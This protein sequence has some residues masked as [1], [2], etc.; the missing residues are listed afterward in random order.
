MHELGLREAARL[1]ARAREAV[2]RHKAVAADVE[3]LARRLGVAEAGDKGVGEVGD[4]A[5]L[6]D[7]VWF[8]LVVGSFFVVGG[9]KGAGW[10][11]CS[12]HAHRK[13]HSSDTHRR[14]KTK[15][16]STTNL[17]AAAGHDDGAAGGEAVEEVLLDGVVVE[18]AVDVDGADARVVDA[19][20]REQRLRLQLALFGV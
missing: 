8:F 5:E 12:W 15:T 11:S 7:L 4:V 13:K 10:A 9:G 1:R 19:A 3:D 16:K 18:R 6:R 14:T 17:H 20:R 2:E